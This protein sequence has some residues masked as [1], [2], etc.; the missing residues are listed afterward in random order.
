MQRCKECFL[1]LNQQLLCTSVEG[2]SGLY[3]YRSAKELALAYGAL[4]H[5]RKFANN[6]RGMGGL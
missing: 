2:R 5:R 1:K 4:A 6:H 3:Q